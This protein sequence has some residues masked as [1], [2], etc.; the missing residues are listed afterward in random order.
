MGV[1][2]PH[3]GDRSGVRCG[4]VVP[5]PH[6]KGVGRAHGC[7]F[8]GAGAPVVC[9]GRGLEGPCLMRQASK[10]PAPKPAPDT[11][12]Q[13]KCRQVRG[14]MAG[15]GQAHEQDRPPMAV[16]QSR[17]R[18][19]EPAQHTVRQAQ[20][21]RRCVACGMDGRHP[22]FTPAAGC[23]CGPRQERS[24]Q[25]LASQAYR[26]SLLMSGE[27]VSSSA[28][29]LLR[30]VPTMLRIEPTWARHTAGRVTQLTCFIQSS[31]AGMPDMP[32]GFL[33]T[34]TVPMA[35]AFSALRGGRR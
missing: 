11:L 34:D 6:R 22:T 9:F 27:M 14:I 16:R 2:V 12:G 30:T 25:D 20:H 1:S 35:C 18:R 8:G 3:A 15:A 17:H 29:T 24:G 23:P 13:G 19:G 32:A 33:A 5:G 7:S 31:S 28:P 10:P 4:R 21:Q 26:P